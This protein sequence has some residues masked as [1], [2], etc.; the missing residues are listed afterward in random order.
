G[1][2][3]A[4]SIAVIGAAIQAGAALLD[5]MI[6]FSFAALFDPITNQ[7][8]AILGQVYALFTATIF[9]ATGGAEMMI[10]GLA[11]SYAVVPID[12]YPDLTPL[13]HRA[14]A[15]FSQLFL[16]ALEVAAPPLI[17]ILVTDAAFALVSRAV[18][19]MNVFVVGMPAKILAG[20]ATIAVS[21]PFL[22]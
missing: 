2:A 20:V 8:N 16:I 9:I 11:K 17:A 15:A 5:T 18:P 22:A 12:A 10:V 7:Q 6:G 19:Q 21:L 4:F 3:F 1:T 14:T 13:G